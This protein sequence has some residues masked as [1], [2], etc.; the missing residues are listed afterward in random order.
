MNICTTFGLKK[1]SPV[2]NFVLLIRVILWNGSEA[3]TVSQY[4]QA[5][6][7]GGRG[8]HGVS[9][10]TVKKNTSAKA[11]GEKLLRPHISVYRHRLHDA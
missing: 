6:V 8:C 1:S 4:C 9:F 11:F 7:A 10:H 2:K 3:G 5:G